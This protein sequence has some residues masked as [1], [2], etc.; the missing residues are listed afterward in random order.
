MKRI[1]IPQTVAA[2]MLLWAL[3]PQNPYGY[4]ILL[5]CVCCATFAYL[6]VKAFEQ[7]KQG[8]VWVL[9]VTAFVYNPII[10][11]HLTRGIWSV[12]NIVSVAIIVASAFALVQAP[13]A[14]KDIEEHSDFTSSTWTR[15]GNPRQESGGE[16]AHND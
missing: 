13:P 8:W 5:R 14:R 11:L 9:G 2:V 3:N 1:W 6:A 12:V 7:K 4:Y 15:H 10:P 16:Y